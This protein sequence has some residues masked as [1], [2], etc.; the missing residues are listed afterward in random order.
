MNSFKFVGIEV[1]CRAA[2][3]IHSVVSGI[4]AEEGAGTDSQ[5]VHAILLYGATQIGNRVQGEA[6]SNFNGIS[7]RDDYEFVSSQLRFTY[8]V[9]LGR[10]RSAVTDV[11]HFEYRFHRFN[12]RRGPGSIEKKDGFSGW[13][14][15]GQR[16]SQLGISR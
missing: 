4:A 15:R 16:C 2:G 14:G 5:V 13:Y 8:C 11:E 12:V 10:V 1:E 6:L 7:A 3:E 9:Q